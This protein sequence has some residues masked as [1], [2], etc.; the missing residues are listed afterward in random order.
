M[1]STAHL[2]SPFEQL[3][4]QNI[5]IERGFPKVGMTGKSGEILLDPPRYDARIFASKQITDELL[6]L[7][8]V[9]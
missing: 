8:K 1:A 5:F 4:Y 3:G 9:S 6:R 2:V 7:E